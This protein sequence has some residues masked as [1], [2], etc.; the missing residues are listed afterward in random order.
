MST[1]NNELYSVE[2]SDST[3]YVRFQFD[4]SQ[5]ANEI[6]EEYR[7]D[8]VNLDNLLSS[9]P[10]AVGYHEPSPV[11]DPG[12]PDE[13]LI[14]SDRKNKLEEVAEKVLKQ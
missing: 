12:N 2:Y 14:T 11:I 13:I 9:V 6:V 10:R 1:T 3:P 8:K 4:D 5:T 7:R